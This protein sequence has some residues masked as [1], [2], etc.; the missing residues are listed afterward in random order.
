MFRLVDRLEHYEVHC[1]SSLDL[2]HQMHEVGLRVSSLGVFV[3][4]CQAPYLKDFCL[5][6]MISRTCKKIMREEC[7][8]DYEESLKNLVYLLTEE[9]EG[10]HDF[11]SKVLS[12]QIYEKFHYQI[13]HEP[14]RV[15]RGG[16]LLSL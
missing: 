4:M 6:E 2:V 7:E 8:G 16:L 11:W 10:S 15:P 9:R 3:E 1:L 12:K 13:G 5:I 14:S